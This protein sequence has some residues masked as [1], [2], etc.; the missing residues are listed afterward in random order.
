MQARTHSGEKRVLLPN[1]R[2]LLLPPTPDDVGDVVAQ[3]GA[4][5]GPADLPLALHG[6]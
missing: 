4:Y 6:A 3:K 2:W 5:V 1:R